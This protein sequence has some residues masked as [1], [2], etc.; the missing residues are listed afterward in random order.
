MNEEIL[1]NYPEL[2]VEAENNPGSR[3]LLATSET[4][5]IGFKPPSV[6]RP[7]DLVGVALFGDGVG[8]MIIDSDR[9]FETETPMLEEGIS[10]TIATELPQIIEDN[11]EGFCD[12][13]IDVVGNTIVHVLEYML[14][15]GKKIKKVGGRDSEWGLMLA[16][17]L[18]ITFE[19]I[20]ARNLCA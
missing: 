12:K 11:V 19:G 7:Y 3:V 6:D 1:K 13:L 8:A 2:T 18:G 5:I 15:E 10:F 16:F 4:T 20:L 14:E 9:V 17:G